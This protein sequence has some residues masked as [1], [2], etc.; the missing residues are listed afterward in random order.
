[1]SDVLTGRVLLV[2]RARKNG[3]TLVED[4]QIKLGEG[5]DEEWVF[6]KKN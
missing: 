3:R 5:N 2:H 1:M 6:A 4:G